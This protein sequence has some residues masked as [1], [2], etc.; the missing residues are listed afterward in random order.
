[1]RRVLA[2]IYP[3]TCTASAPACVDETL[4]PA[5]D[6][7]PCFSCQ[8]RLPEDRISLLICVMLTLSLPSRSHRN[9]DDSALP[10]TKQRKKIVSPSANY[11][12]TQ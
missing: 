3:Q 6:I 11:P 5:D 8:A 12:K 2:V 7:M 1:M 10:N 9:G 4:D